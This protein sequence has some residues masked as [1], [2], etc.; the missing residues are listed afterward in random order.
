[1]ETSALIS[2]CKEGDSHALYLLYQQYKPQLLGICKQYANDDG[3]AEDLLHD[4]FVVILTSLDRLRDAAKLESWMISI[5][6]NVGFH[7]RKQLNKEQAALKQMA[8]E[9]QDAAETTLMPDYDQLQALVMQLPKGYQ[10]VFRLSVFE[11]LSHQEISHLL[12]IAP[13][14]SSS[15]L[16]HAKRM[17]QALIK[18]SWVLILLLIAIPTAV[19]KMLHK[20]KPE[21]KPTAATPKPHQ[22]K[23]EPIVETPHDKPAYVSLG[24]RPARHPIR[25]QTEAVIQPD[26]IPYYNIEELADTLTKVTQKPQ[27]AEFTQDTLIYQHIP[28]P[29]LD[30]THLIASTKTKQSSWDIR[31]AYNGQMGQNSVNITPTSIYAN[32][33]ASASNSYIPTGYSF[34]NWI[35]YS[36]SLNNVLP[37]NGITP[38]TRSMKEI[39]AKNSMINHGKMVAQH[40]YQIPFTIQL[41]LSHPLG[42]AAL[43]GEELSKHLSLETGLSYTRLNST[44]TTGSPEAYIQ[45]QQRL[46]YLGIPLRLNWQWYSH[47]HLSIYS[48]AGAMM[49]LPIHSTLDVK[50]ALDGSTTF[51]N[52]VTLDVPFQW[53]ATLGL[54]IQY[55]L[56]PHLGLYLEP[57]LQYFFDDGSELKS[58]RT[59]H[60]LQFSLP[61]GLRFHW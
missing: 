61:I 20:P 28:L 46:Q 54:G 39:A 52:K 40:S 37:A 24:K 42:S 45:E 16:S 17:L 3:A 4:A 33:F 19:W 50:H 47:A 32:S 5:V 6:R 7:Y 15:Q 2:R 34:S 25:Y 12:G 51:R 57:S 26:S 29:P 58:Y 27:K 41:T 21:T 38:E 44:N 22:Q 53:S 18:Q 1:M 14:S 43:L 35:D 59:E 13:H 9:N 48:S 36:W 49:E 60:P 23:P 31:L 56:T 10:Q 55:D 8:S 11:G 30:D